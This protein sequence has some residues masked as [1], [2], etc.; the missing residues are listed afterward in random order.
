M[1]RVRVLLSLIPVVLLALAQ[2]ATPGVGGEAPDPADCRAEPRDADELIALWYEEDAAG[3]PVAVAPTDEPPLDAVPVPLGEPADAAT[4]AGVTA[5]VREVFACFNA[6]NFGA[7]LALFSDD[8]V[9][10]FGP[11]PGETP[12]EVRGFVEAAPEPPPAG[13]RIRLLAVTDVA[14]MADGRVAAFVVSEDPTVPPEGAE[15]VLVL[16]VEEGGRWLIDW[17]VEFAPVE[18]DG[19]GEGTPAP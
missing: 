15:T 7:A 19:G 11:E 16:L 12:E 6:G 13:E 4:A 1:R 9:H 10:A 18:G 2:D 3:T 8:L 17:V 14:V 5:A